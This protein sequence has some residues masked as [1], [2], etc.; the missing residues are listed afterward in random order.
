[1]LILYIKDNRYRYFIFPKTG[2]EIFYYVFGRNLKFIES[3]ISNFIKLG[4]NFNVILCSRSYLNKDF[5]CIIRE[6]LEKL[7][8]TV[9]SKNIQMKYL[10]L[11]NID[12]LLINVISCS[13]AI[14]PIYI[15]PLSQVLSSFALGFQAQ[16]YTDMSEIILNYNYIT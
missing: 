2:R 8:A 14:I 4:K 11:A 15:L 5:R 3:Q 16:N 10:F 13:V 1:M 12:N 9:V 6:Y 7:K